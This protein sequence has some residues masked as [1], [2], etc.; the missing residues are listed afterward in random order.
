MNQ[1]HKTARAKRA[2]SG[3]E[4]VLSYAD[5]AA[6]GYGSRVTIWRKVT[7]GKFPPPLD[8]GGGRIGWPESAI[9]AWLEERPIAAIGNFAA[10]G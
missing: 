6:L 9:V 4:R 3:A 10:T 2:L 7:L 8:L 1:A 5:P